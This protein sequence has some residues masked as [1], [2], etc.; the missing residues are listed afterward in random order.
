M[1]EFHDPLELFRAAVEAINA[2]DWP[3]AVA[4]VDPVSVRAFH[5]QLIEQFTPSEPRP[6]P[7]VDDLLRHSP[8]M[9][10]AV[11]EHQV[12]EMRR[13]RDPAELLAREFTKVRSVDELRALAPEEALAQWLEVRSLGGQIARMVAAGRAPAQALDAFRAGLLPR[14]NYVALGVVLDG[15]DFADIVYRN[16]AN[17]THEPKGE[18]ADWLAQRPDDERQL[19]RAMW[20]RGHPRIATARRQPDGTWRL[21]VEHDFLGVG[22]THIAQIGVGGGE[23]GGGGGGGAAAGGT[24]GGDAVGGDPGQ[25]KPTKTN[26]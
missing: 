1:P 18:V 12:A 17:P 10:R 5:R 8:E 16:D 4:L 20:T 9:P 21:L 2:E 25:T 24:N 23:R 15:D 14:Y 7:T 19:A 11:A 26:E 3:A 6:M 13:R 22:K